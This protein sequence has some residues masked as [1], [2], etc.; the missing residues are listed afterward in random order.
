M[1]RI[2]F[3]LPADAPETTSRYIGEHHFTYGV[4]CRLTVHLDVPGIDF[5]RTALV[6]VGRA[7]AGKISA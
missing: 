2:E 4:Y 5:A 3:D 6:K 7:G 1:C